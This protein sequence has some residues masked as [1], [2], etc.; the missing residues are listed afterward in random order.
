MRQRPSSCRRRTVPRQRRLGR[1]RRVAR[2]QERA[3]HVQ[4]RRAALLRV[5]LRRVHLRAPHACA[6]GRYVQ[7]PM[8]AAQLYK[9]R[10]PQGPHDVLR[11]GRAAWCEGRAE[12]RAARHV[13]VQKGALCRESC[14]TSPCVCTRWC[15][16][17]AGVCL[18]HVP[19]RWLGPQFAGL[20]IPASLP[21]HGTLQQPSTRRPPAQGRPRPGSTSPRLT[22][23]TNSPPYS[24][25]AS[26][27]SA[28]AG[29]GSARNVCTK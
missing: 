28:L 15:S 24:V 16:A 4:A 17:I 19:W 6:V 1:E 13:C 25:V 9:R 3:Q 12:L 29:S 18:T 21:H 20:R 14:S 26:T 10:G 5:E 8:R 22:A 7:P 11:R 2:V 23:D 27:Q